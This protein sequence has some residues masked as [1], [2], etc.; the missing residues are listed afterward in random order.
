MDQ[1]LY[2]FRFLTSKGRT[3]VRLSSERFW[4]QDFSEGAKEKFKT[5]YQHTF[6]PNHFVGSEQGCADGRAQPL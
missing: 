6:I 4:K 3:P 2:V 5:L 1:G